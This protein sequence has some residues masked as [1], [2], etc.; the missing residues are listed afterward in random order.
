MDNK[1]RVL[2]HIIGWVYPTLFT[3]VMVVLA[4]TCTDTCAGIDPIY[5]DYGIGKC[6]ECN[7]SKGSVVQSGATG[8]KGLWSSRVQLV[9]RVYGPVGCNWSKGSVV[10][11]G[12]T[13]QKGLWSSRVQLVERVC[14]P[15]GCN[16][17]KG[18]VVQSGA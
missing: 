18:S 8:Q 1:Y 14:G 7:W 3:L 17:S 5:R 13:G 9:E 11:S 16:W 2:S 15:V 4:V 6:C 12:A 10:Q